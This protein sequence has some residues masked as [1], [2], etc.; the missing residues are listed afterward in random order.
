[1]TTE[2][3]IDSLLPNEMAKPKVSLRNWEIVC[4]GNFIGSFGTAILIFFSKEYTFGGGGIGV[5]ALEIASEKLN[6][7]FL[8]AIVLGLL[9][10][11]LVCLPSG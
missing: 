9:C 6:L 3:R 11:I 2:K 8:E 1:M 7:D 5:T 4:I 10:N